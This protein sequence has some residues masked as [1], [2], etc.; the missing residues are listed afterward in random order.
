MHAL[1]VHRGMTQ[2][3]PGTSGGFGLSAMADT[4]AGPVSSG[5][6]PCMIILNSSLMG[7][8]SASPGAVG[9]A[10]PGAFACLGAD[11]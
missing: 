11:H 6:K 4:T 8:N 7:W 9:A 3:S 10:K 5:R 1:C 2:G